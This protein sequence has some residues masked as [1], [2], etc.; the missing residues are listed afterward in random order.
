MA[1]L[2]DILAKNIAYLRN[3][4]GLTQAELAQMLNY[5]DKSVSKWER[6]DGVPDVAVLVQMA[7]IFHVTLD[8]LVTEHTKQRPPRMKN[9]MTR[10]QQLISVIALLGVFSLA[11]TVFFSFWISG[12]VVW[13]V[14][15]AV[16]PVMCVVYLVLNS[17]WGKGANNLYVISALL[18]TLLLFFY[19]LFLKH[20]LWL[21]F[22]LGV[23]AQAAVVLAF[24]I[25]L[26]RWFK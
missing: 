13:Q 1:E 25:R 5:S 8:W 6:G 24:K 11:L 10:N 23:P 19:V 21:L 22:L 9:G 7:E 2:R 18:W 4:A 20:N 12:K 14:F 3:H 16:L 26:T 15:I 17:V